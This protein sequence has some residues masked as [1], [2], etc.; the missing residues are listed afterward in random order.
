MSL[1]ALMMMKVQDDEATP[2]GLATSAL[3]IVC[4]VIVVGI[5]IMYDFG[6]KQRCCGGS[7]EASSKNVKKTSSTQVQPINTNN[8]TMLDVHA[9]TTQQQEDSQMLRNWGTESPNS[10]LNMAAQATTPAP[11]PA[12][13]A[14]AK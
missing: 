11:A 12:S 2:I 10:T 8:E 1:G 5:M 6:L 13:I 9:R 4:I 3:P 14:A 7:R